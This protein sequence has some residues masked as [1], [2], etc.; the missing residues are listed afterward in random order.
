MTPQDIGD[1]FLRDYLIAMYVATLGVVQIGVSHGGITR[2]MFLPGRGATR[3]LGYALLIAAFAFFFTVPL[4]DDGP[5][6]AEV[7]GGVTGREGKAVEWSTSSWA[8]LSG[9]RN[10]NDVDGGFSG[11]SQGI[12]FPLAAGLA[13]FSTF[14]ISSAVHHSKSPSTRGVIDG[15]GVEALK[16]FTWVRY[17]G[18]SV[19]HWRASWRDEIERE[20]QPGLPW[21]GVRWLVY[22]WR[23]R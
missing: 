20:F 6:G 23:T 10:I 8:D 11:G 12:W 16:N 14:L 21:G 15:D 3:L 17:V 2:L 5:W 4:W 7:A 22:R 13:L 19:R 18:A 1:I 9:A